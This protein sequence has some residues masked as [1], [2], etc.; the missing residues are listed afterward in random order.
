MSLVPR[1][2]AVTEAAE[3]LIDQIAAT[4]R[5]GDDPATRACRPSSPGLPMPLYSCD[6]ADASTGT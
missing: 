4:V 2:P 5:A 1:P 3:L 6:C